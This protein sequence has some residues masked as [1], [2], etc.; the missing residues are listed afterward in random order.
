[1]TS[2]S[3]D[4]TTLTVVF[5]NRNHFKLSVPSNYS[6]GDIYIYLPTMIGKTYEDLLYISCDG[7]II[8]QQY[9][10]LNKTV[11]YLI[12]VI[13][14]VFKAKNVKYGNSDLIAYKNVKK[15]S[16]SLERIR[17]TISVVA[18]NLGAHAP[19]PAQTQLQP[20]Y[21]QNLLTNGNL[22]DMF[23]E[24][25]INYDDLIDRTLTIDDADYADYVTVPES[26][27]DDNC[28]ICHIDLQS[29]HYDVAE[30]SCHHQFH[31]ECIKQWLTERSVRCP[32]C[33]FD[34]RTTT[35]TNPLL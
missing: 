1:M 31:S 28:A 23:F 18:N 12:G 27:S 3:N 21:L 10:D 9:E 5:G 6:V 35:V 20:Q 7:K 2:P 29:A 8:G 24:G 33:Q 26:I 34:V 14:M 15:Y 19:A 22:V 32:T 16:S 13:N 30:L 11:K 17:G 25:N 4:T